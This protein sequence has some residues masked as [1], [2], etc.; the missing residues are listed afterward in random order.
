MVDMR[1]GQQH[2][3]HTAGLNGK[4]GRQFDVNALRQPA[5]N[6]KPLTAG[7]YKMTAPCYFARRSEK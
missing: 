2:E 4:P 1:V 3:I 5:I 6:K 7:L